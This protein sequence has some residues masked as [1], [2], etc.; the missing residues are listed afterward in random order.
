MVRDLPVSREHISN[1]SKLHLADARRTL[2]GGKRQVYELHEAGHFGLRL[3]GQ[4]L[5]HPCRYGHCGDVKCR[6]VD[7]CDNAA[8]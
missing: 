1:I 8:D 3:P 7:R 5:C 2:S 6:R 4:D